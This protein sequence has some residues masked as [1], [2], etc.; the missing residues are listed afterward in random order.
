VPHR[1]RRTGCRDADRGEPVFK[2]VE[3]RRL[4]E[5]GVNRHRL[6]P[7]LKRLDSGSRAAS[8]AHARLCR[9]VRLAFALVALSFGAA[10]SAQLFSRFGDVHWVD[11]DG[12]TRTLDD[13]RGRPVVMT[14]AYTAC[15]KT[16]SSSM[17]VMRKMQEILAR[18]RR[19]VAFVVVS[20]DPARDSPAEWRRYREARRLPVSWHFLSGAE[21]DTRRLADFL[22]LKYWVYDEHV[23]HD[24]RIV[25]FDA[26]G[27]RKR[28]ILWEQFPDL[29]RELAGL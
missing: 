24:F 20:Y 22:E 3:R 9:L 5:R 4:S 10:A 16:C 27:N 25:V 26:D 13:Y 18:Q 11:S 23:M 14:L 1:I 12:A 29:E 21:A 7:G 17:L 6:V 19:D 28:D 15:R 8:A 2:S